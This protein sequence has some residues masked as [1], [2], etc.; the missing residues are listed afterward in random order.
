MHKVSSH[1]DG[2][3]SACFYIRAVNSAACCD[4]IYMHS[5]CAWMHGC[6]VCSRGCCCKFRSNHASS[7]C[8]AALAFMH[9]ACMNAGIS[10]VHKPKKFYVWP[11]DALTSSTIDRVSFHSN[12]TLCESSLIPPVIPAIVL[13]LFSPQHPSDVADS[14]KRAPRRPAFRP[15]LHH[16]DDPCR[17]TDDVSLSFVHRRKRLTLGLWRTNGSC[18]AWLW[19]R[20]SRS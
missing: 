6:M 15:S 5:F 16:V 9:D 8:R 18:I 20:S 12:T 2:A 10:R 13:F 17:L 4:A 14:A 11:F 1:A 3:A 7:V 19:S